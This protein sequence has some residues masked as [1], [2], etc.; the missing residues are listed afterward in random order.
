[1]PR[2][3]YTEE[4][5]T[6]AVELYRQHGPAEASRRLGIAKGT[7]TRWAQARGV[8]TVSVANNEA[9]V[10]AARARAAGLREAIRLKLLEKAHDALCRMDEPHK[11]FRGKDADE[12]WWD[13]A[14]SGDVKNYATSAAI[15]LDKYRLEVGE[16]TSRSEVHTVDEMDRRL[17]QL[18]AEMDRGAE[19]RVPR[20]APRA[21]AAKGSV[22]GNGQAPPASA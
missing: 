17:A 14:P 22:G 1:M 5:R 9:A 19:T 6:E 4:E 13:K 7:I 12:V 20:E 10:E 3:T 11:D 21:D 8:E 18:V 16:S 15:L 2:R